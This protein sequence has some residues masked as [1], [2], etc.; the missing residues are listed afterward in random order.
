MAGIKEIEL[1]W[2]RQFRESELM[3][4]GAYNADLAAQLFYGFDDPATAPFGGSF[5]ELIQEC[6]PDNTAQDLTLA[7]RY[8]EYIGMDIPAGT[9][10]EAEAERRHSAEEIL[11]KAHDIF[12]CLAKP[13][14]RIDPDDPFRDCL[15]PFY[16]FLLLAARRP[17]AGRN[18]KPAPPRP[19][20]AA[21]SVPEF[22]GTSAEIPEGYEN[23]RFAMDLFRRLD[24]GDES[25]FLT[26]RAGTGK[27][28]F[29]HYFV[30]N[31][32]K[33]V[34]VL[35]F[36]GIAAMNIGGQTI[37]SF[38]RLPL[39]PLLPGDEEITLFRKHDRRRKI[40]RE[41]DTII[42][43]EVSMLR[44]DVLEAMD[45]SLRMNGGRGDLPFGGKQIV[46]VGDIFQLPPVIDER[47]EVESELFS[48]VYA[49]QYFFDAPSY[50]ELAPTTIEL[51]RIHRQTNREF[52]DLLNQVRDCTIAP[53]GLD[54]LNARYDP[55]YEP[56]REEFT[57]TLTSV[58]R[59]ANAENKRRMS[60]LAGPGYFYRATVDG[61]FGKDR[62]PTEE[63][64]EL[65]EGAQVMFVRNDTHERGNRWVNGT[66]ALVTALGGDFI[67]VRL[68]DGTVHNVKREAWDNCRYQ[69]D[70]KAGRITS[71]V[72]GTFAQYPVKPAWAVTI[73]K[74]QGLTFDRVVIDL[75]RG[76][77]VNGQLYTALSRCRSLEGIVLKQKIRESDVIG[78]P[79]LLA[80]ARETGTNVP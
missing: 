5:L 27:S 42:I 10:I 1:R 14:I 19:E 56:S 8:L 50:R 30:Q 43:D 18:G 26:G 52:I 16:F 74:S 75:G 46:F 15:Q 62:Y 73:H 7:A 29:V 76:A 34:L 79:R 41:V 67:E 57:I 31:T 20:P 35:A 48:T 65:R 11:R 51:S 59:L 24:D 21:R 25:I 69:W 68:Q 80:F 60:E 36:T 44:A 40:I 47:N 12:R 49:S 78:D 28:T 39:K 23:D 66:I 22:F 45:R 55:A 13:G 33:N 61:E 53:A 17:I 2:K 71:E 38:F 72:L 6:D 58:N 4:T 54:S 64:L 63:V 32:G 9:L 37:H 70:R 3:A 77:F